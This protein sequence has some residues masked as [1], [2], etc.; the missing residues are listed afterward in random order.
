L[1]KDDF[2]TT[3]DIQEAVGAILGELSNGENDDEF[4]FELC[5][6]FLD[7]LQWL[8][9]FSLEYLNL[10]IKNKYPFLVPIL[11]KH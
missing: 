2:A 5:S 11:K 8:N 3:E 9:I 1:N 10:K 7:I 4:I 6:K